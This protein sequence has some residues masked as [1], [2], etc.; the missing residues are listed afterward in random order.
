VRSYRRLAT[1]APDPA[2]ALLMHLLIEDED[3]YH[4]RLQQM[5]TRLQYALE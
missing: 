5:A 4:A 2:V 1:T 3:C